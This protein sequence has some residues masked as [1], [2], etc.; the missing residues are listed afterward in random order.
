MRNEIC[1]L[2]ELAEVQADDLA[3][4]H[5]TVARE[6]VH[7]VERQ[8]RRE[9]I[10]VFAQDRGGDSHKRAHK[11]VVAHRILSIRA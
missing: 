11:N 3:A 4:Q 8:E 7:D 6:P 5:H 1:A 10:P 9:Q 2:S